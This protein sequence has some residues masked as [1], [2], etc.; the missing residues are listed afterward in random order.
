MISSSKLSFLTFSP[1]ASFLPP[2]SL[3]RPSF[4]LAQTKPQTPFFSQGFQRYFA[5]KPF[6]GQSMSPHP[7]KNSPLRVDDVSKKMGKL[8]RELAQIVKNELEDFQF[9]RESTRRITQEI[10]R[11]WKIQVDRH[12]IYLQSKVI[13]SLTLSCSLEPKSSEDLDEDYYKQEDENEEEHEEKHQFLP[14][15]EDEKRIFHSEGPKPFSELSPEDLKGLESQ[16]PSLA[17]SIQ[18]KFGA[19]TWNINAEINSGAEFLIQ[20][21]AIQK[22][23]EDEEMVVSAEI[24]N[25]SDSLQGK[26][27]Q[28]LQT[29]GID[30]H[31][32]RLL[33]E[34]VE[35]N[36]TNSQVTVLERIYESTKE[37]K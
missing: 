30:F 27:G 6:P 9:V 13:P 23:G 19:N 5:Q 4:A 17:T 20:E 28:I 32:G 8:Q 22:E 34:F 14:E 18:L 11:A 16:I 2:L 31:L 24:H 15:K 25:F 29:G 37:Y 3:S 1:R 35:L 26:I 21:I 10:E 7:Q 12:E 36:E 33:Q